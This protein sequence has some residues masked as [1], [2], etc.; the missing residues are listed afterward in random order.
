M[1]R[2]L[3]LIPAQAGRQL[4]GLDGLIGHFAEGRRLF[5][6][7]M[8]V[9][10]ED[11]VRIARRDLTAA[12]RKSR[13]DPRHRGR[14]IVGGERQAAVEIRVEAAD[15][16]L[17]RPLQIGGEAHFL[18]ETLVILDFLD[19][20]RLRCAAGEAEVIPAYTKS[21]SSSVSSTLR[22]K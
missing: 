2:F 20:A 14:R 16:E 11:Q 15:D 4:E 13:I 1:R 12:A 9:R 19:A 7:G 8:I 10:R 6:V 22:V 21:L 17:N 18:D 5:D 3:H